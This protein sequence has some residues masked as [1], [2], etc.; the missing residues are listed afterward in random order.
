MYQGTGA[1]GNKA[2]LQTRL[3]AA[4]QAQGDLKSWI[5]QNDEEEWWSKISQD[6][7]SALGAADQR[8]YKMFRLEQ[9]RQGMHGDQKRL[10][11]L[12]DEE[13]QSVHPLS[14]A[15]SAEH[16][17][18]AA[19]AES[20]DF[21]LPELQEVIARYQAGDRSKVVRSARKA[22]AASQ[23][24]GQGNQVAAAQAAGSDWD[25]SS[26]QQA[27]EQADPQDLSSYKYAAGNYPLE[28]C[29]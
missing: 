15:A 23:A 8:I 20:G 14:P 21:D 7:P 24:G 6:E 16:Q 2:E 22:S 18:I 12:V 11:D 1:A 27:A 5:K 19:F 28:G 29:A 4:R 26:Q 17:A 25:Q 9:R 10:Y 3:L 13:E